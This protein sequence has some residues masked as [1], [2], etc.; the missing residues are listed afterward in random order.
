MVSDEGEQERFSANISCLKLQEVKGRVTWVTVLQKTFEIWIRWN[1]WA[2][3]P[4][5]L[6]CAIGWRFA[7]LS[8]FDSLACGLRSCG[9]GFWG[10][11]SFAGGVLWSVSVYL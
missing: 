11:D 4:R 2:H 10:D 3:T 5:V 6:S 8:L 7:G 1:G 9:A